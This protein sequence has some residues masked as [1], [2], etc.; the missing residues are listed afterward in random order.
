MA[1]NVEKHDGEPTVYSTMGGNAPVFCNVL[2]AEP[3]PEIAART[4]GDD[5]YLL[6]ERFQMDGA[7]TRAIEAIG[8]AG[9]M[10]DI[11]R[12]RK[13]SKHKREIQRERQRLGRLANF[14][15]AEWR[16]H[17]AEE[18]QMRDQEKATIERLVAAR[19]MERMEIYLHYHDDHAY[20][21]RGHMRNDI[22]RSGWSEIERSSGQETLKS[23]PEMYGSWDAP[24]RQ[25]GPPTEVN[26]PS[27]KSSSL[28]VASGSQPLTMEQKTKITRKRRSRC[29]YCT[30][31]GH[32]AKDC[33]A[34]H[35]MCH[36]FGDGKCVVPK[37]HKH[38]CPMTKPICPYVGFHSVVLYKQVERSGIDDGEEVNEL[39]E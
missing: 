14:L 25:A 39:A 27:T 38:Y 4:E 1:F 23:L 8:D 11:I 10:A 7:V 3:R 9:V 26:T 35:R 31:V 18:K 5:V 36:R 24:R 28:S 22:I 20:L 2:H 13:F 15:T 33:T 37:T 21:T 19:T 32:F 30:V 12:L 16:R 34:P 29:K 6:G 17:Y